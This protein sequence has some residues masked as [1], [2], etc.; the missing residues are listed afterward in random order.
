MVEVPTRHRFGLEHEAGYMHPLC[1]L[2]AANMTPCLQLLVDIA[3]DI[4]QEICSIAYCFFI[5]D[6]PWE[7]SQTSRYFRELNTNALSR[8]DVWLHS[9]KKTHRSAM[10]RIPCQQGILTN[11]DNPCR[12]RQ[13]GGHC[14]VSTQGLPDCG[15]VHLRVSESLI[16]WPESTCAFL[17]PNSL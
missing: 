14:S 11:D 7:P 17:L 10:C 15:W 1:L 13:R 8:R 2:V 9:S 5:Q 16:L 4:Q 6:R 3:K 12:G